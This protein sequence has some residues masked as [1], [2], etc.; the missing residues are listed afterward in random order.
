LSLISIVSIPWRRWA[1]TLALV[2]P[3]CLAML[4]RASAAVK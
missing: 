4:L 3:L 1:V 2:A